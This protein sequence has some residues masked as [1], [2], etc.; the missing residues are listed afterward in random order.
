MYIC[1]DC[2]EEVD[3]QDSS[4]HAKSFPEPLC[5]LCMKDLKDENYKG[6]RI[7]KFIPKTEE[8]K[9]LNEIFGNPY[10]DKRTFR[11][12][13]SQINIDFEKSRLNAKNS[14]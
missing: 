1:A 12:G 4:K 2:G 10:N 3:E 7:E 6:G 11:K 14:N 5:Q 9:L 13:S 8:E